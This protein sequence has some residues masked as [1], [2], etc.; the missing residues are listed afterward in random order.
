MTAPT[1]G[2][3]HHFSAILIPHPTTDAFDISTSEEGFGVLE[4][5]TDLLAVENSMFFDTE[6]SDADYVTHSVAFE[7]EDGV[8]YNGNTPEALSNLTI[9]FEPN[10]DEGATGETAR[11]LIEDTA[12]HG[13]YDAFIF[14]NQGATTYVHKMVGLPLAITKPKSNDFGKVTQT[15]TAKAKSEASVTYNVLKDTYPAA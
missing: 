11:A 9:E 3:N 6:D 10:S 8:T 5:K 12:R 4:M 1:K 2:L 13:N 7:S 15:L 14:D